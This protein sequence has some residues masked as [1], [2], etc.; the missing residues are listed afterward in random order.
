M[1]KG[2]C[3]FFVVFLT[4]VCFY[5]ST[6]FALVEYEET[7]ILTE[8]TDVFDI[9][10]SI[11]IELNKIV[12]TDTLRYSIKMKLNEQT[13]RHIFGEEFQTK[14]IE[15]LDG[16]NNI[17][18]SVKTS[19]WSDKIV[20]EIIKYVPTSIEYYNELNSIIESGKSLKTDLEKIYFLGNYFY[21]NGFKYAYD[22]SVEF[23][24]IKSSTT[25]KNLNA[26]PDGVLAR[27]KAICM[28]F[29][30]VGSEYLTALGIPNVKIRGHNT[31]DNG[32]HVWNI[33]YFE[34]NGKKDWYC[35]DYGYSIHRRSSPN[36]IKTL[37]EYVKEDKYVWEES[38]LEDVIYGK[39]NNDLTL[40]NYDIDEMDTDTINLLEYSKNFSF[41][42]GVS[43]VKSLTSENL[44]NLS[45]YF[46]NICDRMIVVVE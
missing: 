24:N 19:I 26:M 27:K 44:F 31:E 10:N 18:P 23:S 14:L 17:T 32:Y 45:L 33:A 7:M 39:Y 37:D 42:K 43:N 25:Y 1:K 16:V 2:L 4:I 35:V 15:R 6:I 40:K 12:E 36:L 11:M 3:V 13:D 28:G 9:V 22:N 41:L 8:E 38:L 20:F 34:Y 5:N 21:D 46:T 30:N 29:A